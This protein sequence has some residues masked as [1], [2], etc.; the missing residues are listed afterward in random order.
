MKITDRPFQILNLEFT[1]NFNSPTAYWPFYPNP[2]SKEEYYQ[3]NYSEE[4]K[5]ERHQ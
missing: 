4:N 3:S 2:N 1:S 5:Y